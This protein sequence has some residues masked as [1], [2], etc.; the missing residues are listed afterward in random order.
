M[1]FYLLATIQTFAQTGVSIKKLFANIQTETGYRFFYN[2]DLNDIN[3]TIVL[4]ADLTN[5]EAVIQELKAK[6]TLDFKMMENQLIVVVPANAKQQAVIIKG[7]VTTVDEPM[8]L[9][10]V[11]VFVKGTTTGTVTDFEGNYSLEVA[12]NYAIIVFSFIGFEI[13]EV[14]INGRTVI[15]IDLVSDIASLEEVVITALNISRD[16]SSLGYSITQVSNEEL[17]QVRDNN[18][19]NSLAGK[20]AGLQISGT[21]SGV[22]G[23]SRIVLRGIT[24]IDGDNRPLV[25]IDGIPVDGRSYGGTNVNGGSDMGDA[26]SDINPDDIAS[27]SV[28]KGAGAAAAYGSRGANGVI[29]I[30]TKKGS[31]RKGIGVSFNSS[32]ILENPSLFPSMQNTYGQGA[33]GQYP[34]ELYGS[35]D[36][37]KWTEPWIWSWGRP[38]E[39]QILENWVGVDSPYEAQ[40][41]QI[42]NYYQNGFSFINTIALDAG[43]NETS[44]RASL[45]NQNGSGISPGNKIIKQTINLRGFSKVGEKLEVDSK[46]VYIHSKVENRPYLNEDPGNAVWAL[47]TMPR[48]ITLHSLKD[49]TVDENGNEMWF[50]DKTVSN[51]YWVSNNTHN[52]DFKD[53]MQSFLS[54]KYDFNDKLNFII[55]SGLDYTSRN[56]REYAAAGSRNYVSNYEYLGFMSQSFANYLEWNTDFLLAYQQSLGKDFRLNLSLGGNYRY[57]QQKSIW[58]NGY[59]WQAPNFYHMSNVG[60]A[61]TSERLVENEVLS[62]YS[63]AT[64]SYKN[65][66]YTD[67]TYRLDGS[68]TLPAENRYYDF[69]SAN[70]SFLLTEA[71]NIKSNILS[72]GKVRGSIAKVGNDTDP[73]RTSNYYTM[74]ST[75]LA[76]PTGSLSSTLAIENFKP[77]ITTSWELGTEL[78]FFGN[79]VNL[80]FSY[81]DATTKNQI[82]P[83]EL[84]PSSGYA[85]QVINAGE[86]RN[87]G[88]EGLI[89]YSPLGANSPLQWI[90]S[91]NAT[92]NMNQVVA[93]TDEY[94]QAIL[95]TSV[96]GFANVNMKVGET[97]GSIYGYDYLR[98][99]ADEKLIE[100]NGLPM[101]TSEMV[102]LGDINPDLTGGLANNFFYKNINLKFLIDFQFGGEIFSQGNLYRDL[103]G[104]SEASLE[105]RAEWYATHDGPLFANEIPGVIPKGFVEDGVNVNTGM[106]NDVPLDPLARNFNVIYF[107]KIISDYILDATNVRMR[108]L[109]LGYSL[110]QE[111]LAKTSLTKVNVSLVGRNLFFFYNAAKDIDPESGYSAGSYGNAFEMNAMPATRSYGFNLSITF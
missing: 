70:L 72:K 106:Q 98:N 15:D 14:A 87:H 100:D 33:F 6:T 101:S 93:L 80:D 2:D 82:L 64:I 65:Y 42:K 40:P 21:P 56:S 39:G 96:F 32:Y 102:R 85:Y 99:E 63:L 107:D 29:L 3:K 38:M 49:N 4:Q 37:I 59:G 46:F 5:I 54:L 22:D 111:W 57:N 43:N 13:Q 12:D 68:S 78:G 92:K 88:F 76:Y 19:M 105:G 91:L 18:P 74:S 52:E 81:Y 109:S 36:D 69:Y 97:F 61:T 86:I 26:L 60:K 16:K 75:N 58:Q 110:P 27:M 103:F 41:N 9:P 31:S 7:K 77:E 20:V 44:F 47:G 90:L 28:L 8:G 48:N 34:T 71:F 108:E 11:N 35:M 1:L 30:T 55:R 23:S 25:V 10:G 53:R 50:F 62:I 94:D 89:S 79:K 24:S 95:E 73:Y 51:P 83:V 67:L 45:T 104:T 66:L 17:T 84:A